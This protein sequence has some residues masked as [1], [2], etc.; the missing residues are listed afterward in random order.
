MA[1]H[2]ISMA[3][4]KTMNALHHSMDA[5]MAHRFLKVDGGAGAYLQLLCLRTAGFI[6]RPFGLRGLSQLAWYLQRFFAQ[7]NI[8]VVQMSSGVRFRIYLNDGYWIK[9]ICP[10]YHYEPEVQ[11]TLAK[12]LAQPN[13]FFFDCGANMGYWSH[14]VGQLTNAWERIATIE[15]SPPIL[16]AC[17][18]P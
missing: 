3:I 6:A 10:S 13:T 14:F 7:E 12:A 18:K 2:N 4:R 16:N 17:W 15:A 11:F 8:V 9:L 5:A 1:G